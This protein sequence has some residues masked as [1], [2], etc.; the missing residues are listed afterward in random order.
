MN[1]STP[2]DQTLAYYEL[3]AE[4]YAESARLTWDRE[5][6][7]A[8]SKLIPQHGKILDAGCGF[9]RDL[10]YFSKNGF[11]AEGFDGASKMVSLARNRL[12]GTSAQAW[13]SDFRFLNL[14]KE[15]YDGIWAMESLVHLPPVV[16][17]RVVQNFF[18]ALKRGGTLF[19]SFAVSDQ[20]THR[21]DRADGT[22]KNP[23]RH[24]YSYPQSEFESL[25]RQNGFQPLFQGH[26]L[27]RKDQ[28][29]VIA[30][31]I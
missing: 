14:K 28:M 26:S 7:E 22:S 9:G 1:L 19:A 23:P 29:A 4:A 3:N 24:I 25:I 10:E 12:E 30:K 21:E 2:E 18:S 31:R 20:S 11:D 17:L 13:Q 5:A 6:I 27:H 16:C 15:Y 8:F